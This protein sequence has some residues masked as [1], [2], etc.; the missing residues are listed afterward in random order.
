MLGHIIPI[1]KGGD[2][3]L[4]VNYRPV[5]LTSHLIK[6]FEKILRKHIVHHLEQN[7]LFNESQHGFRSGR[8]CLSQLLEHYDKVLT[9]LEA[10][11][12]VDTIYLDFSK[13]FD[14]VDIRALLTK[15]EAIGIRG[16][17]LEWIRIFLTKR[18]QSVIVDGIASN[19]EKVLSGVPQGSVNGPL[20][21]LIMIADIDE[22]IV[23][24]FLSSFADDT[25]VSKA[26]STTNDSKL[27]QK[28]L[29][30]IYKWKLD[31]NMSFNSSKFELIR[32]GRNNDLKTAT[33]YYTDDGSIIEEAS[34]VKDLGVLMSNNCTFREHINDV[35][36]KTKSISSWVL[37]TFNSR[38]ELVMRTLWKS[39]VLPK[40]D[41]CC[42]IW[43][44][45]CAG[46][47][48]QLELIQRQFIR[49]IEGSSNLTYW[50][51]LKVFKFSSL[52]RRRERYLIIYLWKILENL[53]PNIGNN[54]ISCRK[55]IRYGRLCSIRC[56][57]RSTYTNL[58][59]SFFSQLGPRLFN[60]MPK[61]IRNITNCSVDCFKKDL[62]TYLSKVPDEPQIPGY[63][64][65]RRAE[66]NS[67]TDMAK[68]ARPKASERR[69]GHP[70]KPD[71]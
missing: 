4:P 1:H 70:W 57:R 58:R 6:I 35:I 24:S 68:F 66:T 46:D 64:A 47:I 18:K 48:Q 29:D 26:V 55:H 45:H 28:D 15:I 32:Y 49:K 38:N 36:V 39:L 22:D 69:G 23:N 9:H 41:Y 20:F 7:D 2:R 34:T 19:Q 5:T 71:P 59:H 14:K 27:L 8:S 43:N 44:P 17:L 67:L 21:F 53:V 16:K 63:T 40:F 33:S 60:C 25:R 56:T 51:Q 61:Y 42:Q 52:Q 12:N 31:N 62:D 30:R 3:G 11:Y 13:A 37:R 54:V 10:G 50:D 65:C